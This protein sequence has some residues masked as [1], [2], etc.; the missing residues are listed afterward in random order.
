MIIAIIIIISSSSTTIV[1]VITII[2][3]CIIV[4]ISNITVIS[5]HTIIQSL[6]SG[7]NPRSCKPFSCLVNRVFR[8]NHVYV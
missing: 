6:L 3:V 8:V 4:S 5:K 2:I 7:R 1:I